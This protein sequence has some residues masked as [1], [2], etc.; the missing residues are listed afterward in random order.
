MAVNPV[1]GY[2]RSFVFSEKGVSRFRMG[3][4]A[5]SDNPLS[6]ITPT[7]QGLR[8]DDLGNMYSFICMMRA[9]IDILH[10]SHLANAPIQRDLQLVH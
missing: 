5:L 1:T 2:E 10:V 6:Y 3:A 7:P 9:F 4:W 8:V